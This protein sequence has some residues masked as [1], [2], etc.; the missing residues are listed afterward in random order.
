MS[1]PSSSSTPRR[2]FLAQV[3]A[4][5][6]AGSAC[7]TPLAAAPALTR[8]SRGAPAF[9]DS[10]TQRVIAAKHRAVFDG[11]EVNDGLVLEHALAYMT[12]YQEM[13]GTSDT[14]T[15]PVVVMRHMGTVM[16]M[17]DALWEKYELGKRTKLEDPTTGE[18]TKRNP[19]LRVEPTDKFAQ[20]SPGAS[21]AS[22]HARGVVLLA[23]NRALMRFAGDQA[24]QRNLDVEQVRAEMRAGMAPGV[25]LQPS[26][27]YASMRAQEA[28]CGFL[29][30]T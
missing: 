27:I 4:A 10:W 18:E 6:V 14:E 9:D 15:V 23:C 8:A 28:G 12:G 5:V 16:A 24:R 11:P 2:D 25:V 22:L 1:E 7:A 13:F 21:L 26:G 3:A 30:S 17:G 29:R 19:F 20:I